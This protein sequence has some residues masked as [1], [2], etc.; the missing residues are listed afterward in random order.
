ME[1][2]DNPYSPLSGDDPAPVAAQW[3]ENQDPRKLGKASEVPT[4]G[5]LMIVHGVSMIVA[6]CCVIGMFSHFLPQLAQQIEN[7]QQ[8]QRRQNPNGP[9]LSK[10][11]MTT[12][13]YA[14]YGG[15]SAALFVIGVV[16]IIAGLKNCGY[17]SRVF[18]IISLVLNMGSILFCWCAP[19]SLGLLIFGLIIYLSPEADRAF[20]WRTSHP[21]HA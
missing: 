1:N 12:L 6:A 15:M 5:T 17:R 8:V 10:E 18:G 21:D 13:L 14:L 3:D 20:N 19:F 2:V 4:V 9:Q 11:G 7:Q 16:G